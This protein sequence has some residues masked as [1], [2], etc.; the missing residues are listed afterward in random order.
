MQDIA[1]KTFRNGLKAVFVP[2]EAE[3]VAFGLF[4]SSGSRHETAR[5]AG[6]SHFIEHMLFKGTPS[7]KSIDITRAI[8]GRGGNFNACTSEEATIYYTHMP[9]EYLGEAVDILSDMYL[10]AEIDDDEFARERKVIVEEIKMCAD[11]PEQV[12]MENLQRALFAGNQIGEPIAGTAQSLSRMVPGQLRAY[13]KSHYTP[14]RT[15]AVVAGR[16]D[17]NEAASLIEKL[18]GRT[19]R[20]SR[21]KPSAAATL[22]KFGS[23]VP[24]I[25]VA[26]DVQQAQLALGFRTFG[27][28]D[29]RKYAAIVLD[30]ILGRGMS[31][32]LFQEVRENRALSYDIGS[33]ISLMSDVGMFIIQAGFDVSKRDVLLSTIEREI[34]KVCSKKVPREELDRTK[35]FLCGNFRLSHERLLSKLFLHGASM[36]RFGRIISV[37]EQVEAIRKVT[38]DEVRDVANSIFRFENRSASWVLPK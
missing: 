37:D 22:G 15:V 10:N 11:D 27:A 30:G 24:E 8:E 1:I 18:L 38:A 31:S 25:T 5:T 26:K 4:V 32:R 23:V 3:S 14:E 34:K 12:V 36:M 9:F 17:V 35:E 2:C 29:G 33:R 21:R 13:M 7:R 19:G 20:K 28:A 6:I 16:F